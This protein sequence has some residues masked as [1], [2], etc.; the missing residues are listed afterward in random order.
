MGIGLDLY[1]IKVAS[2]WSCRKTD[3]LPLIVRAFPDLA[4][5][6]GREVSGKALVVITIQAKKV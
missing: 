3:G 6:N 2:S 1:L 5:I 4:L